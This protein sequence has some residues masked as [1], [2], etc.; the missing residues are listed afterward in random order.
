MT[1]MGVF[2]NKNTRTKVRGAKIC[3]TAP[4]PY[5]HWTYVWRTH[6]RTPR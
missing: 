2:A 4:R 3:A 6:N 5:G 1:E